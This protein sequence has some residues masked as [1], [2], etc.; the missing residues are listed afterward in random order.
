MTCLQWTSKAT[1]A[2]SNLKRTSYSTPVLQQPRPHL[3]FEVEVDA[4][5]V[6]VGAILI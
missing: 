3:P 1:T 4:S 2:F 6:G 5:E